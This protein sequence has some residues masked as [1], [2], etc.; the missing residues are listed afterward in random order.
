VFQL[1]ATDGDDDPPLVVLSIQSGN[2]AAVRYW[3]GT[4]SNF[5]VA[6]P[7]T[8]T[9]GEWTTVCIRIKTSTSSGGYVLAS[10]NGDPFTGVTNVPCFA[11]LRRTIGRSGARIAASIRCSRTATT[12]S[13]TGRSRRRRSPTSAH[14]P[15][16]RRCE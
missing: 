16:H 3:P 10:V 9:I 11:R 14:R 1:K 13:G 6:R 12:R 7:L 5:L 2:N 15:A 8:Y 4:S